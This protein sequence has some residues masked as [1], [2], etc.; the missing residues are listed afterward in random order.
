MLTRRRRPRRSWAGWPPTSR[1]RTACRFPVRTPT[2]RPPQTSKEFRNQIKAEMMMISWWNTQLG[3]DAWNNLCQFQIWCIYF[4]RPSVCWSD[5]AVSSMSAPPSTFLR[6][7]NTNIII[8]YMTWFLTRLG[9]QI[10]SLGLWEHPV[11]AGPV[12]APL[13]AHLV[14]EV[15]LVRQVACHSRL[16]FIDLASYLCRISKTGQFPHSLNRTICPS[17]CPHL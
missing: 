2:S 16:G 5:M 10:R 13:R 15:Q 6:T 9:A 14:H 11:R 4:V 12:R 8:P 7:V 3:F 1:P 17:Y